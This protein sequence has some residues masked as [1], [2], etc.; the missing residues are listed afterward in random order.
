[1]GLVFSLQ[2]PLER[3]IV[4]HKKITTYIWFYLFG[5]IIG[6]AAILLALIQTLTI[7]LYKYAEAMVKGIDFIVIAD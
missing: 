2:E 4:F 1:M 5:W 7:I 6:P 3:E